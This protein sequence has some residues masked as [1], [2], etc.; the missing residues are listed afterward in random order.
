MKSLGITNQ[1][2]INEI[3]QKIEQNKNKPIL[4]IINLVSKVKIRDKSGLFIGARMGRP[5]KAKM[6]ELTG[7]PHAL[8]PVGEEGGR[9]RCFQSAL[10]IGTIRADFPIFF[11][12]KCNKETI[13]NICLECK[14][15]TKKMHFCKIC[16]VI[17]KEKCIHGDAMSFKTQ[18]LDIKTY[19]NYS[20]KKLKLKTYPDLIKG[21]RGTSNKDHTPEH[22]IKGILRAKHSI[23]VNKDGTTR[24][25]MTQLPITHFKPKEIRTSIERLKELGYDKDVE[26]NE[27]TDINQILELKPQDVIL[28]ACIESPD[29]GA[30]KVLFN[31]A[32]FIDDELVNLYNLQ[33]FYNLEKED[34]L[35]GHLTLALAPHTSAAILARIIG[36]S[37]T[38]GFFA[39]PLLHAATRRDCDG[40]EACIILLM[41]ALIN[42]SR[43]YLPSHRGSSQD[44]PLVLTS[45]LIPTEVDDMVFD[46]DIVWQYPLDFYEACLQHKQPW[47]I[48]IKQIITNI[49]NNVPCTDFGFTH[50]VSNM[51]KGV[52]CSAYKILPSMEEKLKGQMDLAEKISAVDAS[53]VA[54]L[55]IE[56]HFIKDTK[57]NLRKF[58]MQQFR[59]V[60]CNEKYR[61]PPLV[62]KCLK[63][64]GRIIFTISEGSVIKYLNPS[65]SLA[66]KYDVPT[67]LKQNLVLLQRRIEGM[68]GKEKEKQEGLG[69]WFD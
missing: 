60:K 69:K 36:F 19:F 32:K 45:K 68:F 41:D 6:R 34:D 17:P 16:G 25:D 21:V 37:K 31:V 50:N 33:P 27:L 57:G 11:C 54:R 1:N 12:S 48:K 44:A 26:G 40:D 66:N 65:V 46:I 9:L 8:F 59:C 22:L 23:S 14:K 30:D 2:S 29:K 20:L 51:N 15:Q 28:P 55:V 61:R 58:S 39:H 56:K 3:K 52:V 49:E 43:T 13:F 63:C 35:A 5:E 62:G 18:D 67:Y 24:Y 38:Q 53:D 10:D 47:D 42:F 64:N 4:E 7:S